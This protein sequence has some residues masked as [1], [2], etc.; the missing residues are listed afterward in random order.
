MFDQNLENTSVDRK[1]PDRT[2]HATTA[3]E[4]PE[5]LCFLAFSST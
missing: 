2:V 3:L 1:H 4:P 5:F